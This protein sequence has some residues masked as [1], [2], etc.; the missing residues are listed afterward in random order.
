MKKILSV[1][2][3]M[4]LIL[5]LGMVSFADDPVSPPKDNAGNVL[6]DQNDADWTSVKFKKSIT[7]SEERV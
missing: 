6:G 2:L 3:V 4:T 1:I 5:S 7:R